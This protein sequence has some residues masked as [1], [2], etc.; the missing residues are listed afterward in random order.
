MGLFSLLGVGAG[1][2]SGLIDVDG[3]K[4]GFED[5]TGKTGERAAKEAAQ[6]QVDLQQ[7]IID[8]Q[9]PFAEAGTAQLGPLSGSATTEGFGQNI[10]DIM[11]GDGF[12][13][14]LEE[15]QRASQA[16]LSGAGL[17]RS[18]AAATEA[19]NLPT[20]LAFQIEAE[21]NRRRQ[22]LAGI[23]QTGVAGQSQALGNIGQAQAGGILG[24]AQARA[25]GVGNILDIGG[26]I[27][28]AFFRYVTKRKCS[29]YWKY[30]RSGCN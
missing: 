5:I 22:S 20:D 11:R 18:G 25:Q 13:S 2:K 17:R 4:G 30:W 23:G 19:A 27:A 12:G 1:I 7:Q 3:I 24:G 14:M 26:K 16:A 15:R 8:L 21:L 28:G 29:G 6:T 9:R 10:G